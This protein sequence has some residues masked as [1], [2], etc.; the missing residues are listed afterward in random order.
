MKERERREA[1]RE[2]DGWLVQSEREEM[3]RPERGIER[4]SISL[5]SWIPGHT[6]SMTFFTALATASIALSM[7]RMSTEG[8]ISE[9][10]IVSREEHDLEED[11]L[12]L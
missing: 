2:E 5:L 4:S 7:G 6:E 1:E 8:E 9:K 12:S 3:E 10:L 11:A